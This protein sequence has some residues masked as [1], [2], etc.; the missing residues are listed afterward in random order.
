MHKERRKA[1]VKK[2]DSGLK[3]YLLRRDFVPDIKVSILLKSPGTF[4]RRLFLAGTFHEVDR[5]TTLSDL[6]T[7]ECATWSLFEQ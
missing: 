1:T 4:A 2:F 3:F 6:V 5:N 7:V